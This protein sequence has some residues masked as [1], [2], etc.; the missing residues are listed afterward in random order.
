MIFRFILKVT[1]AW[2]DR[3]CVEVDCYV[4]VCWR[5]NRKRTIEL[6]TH[7]RR[8]LQGTSMKCHPTLLMKRD[9]LQ[10]HLTA[11]QVWGNLF[12]FQIKRK[13]HWRRKHFEEL[14]ILEVQRFL[15]LVIGCFSFEASTKSTSCAGVSNDAPPVTW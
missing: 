9:I 5:T 6:Y 1:V 11:L 8:K 14:H 12:D 10:M 13:S 4:D 3:P 7:L 2:S 15:R